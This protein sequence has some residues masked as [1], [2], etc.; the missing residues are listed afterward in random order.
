MRMMYYETVYVLLCYN[1]F[2]WRVYYLQSTYVSLALC[3]TRRRLTWWGCGLAE[4]LRGCRGYLL[5]ERGEAIALICK[6]SG[7]ASIFHDAY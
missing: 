4:A 1:T 3:G 6:K 2:V 7:T 5:G